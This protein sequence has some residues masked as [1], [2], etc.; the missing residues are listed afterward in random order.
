MTIRFISFLLVILF[1]PGASY[2][3]KKGI[4]TSKRNIGGTVAVRDAGKARL[5]DVRFSTQTGR[6][7]VAVAFDRRITYR[8]GRLSKPDRVFFDIE[9]AL[10]PKGVRNTYEVDDGRLR[11]IRIAQ[12]NTDTVRV[13]LDL[14]RIARYSVHAET[15]RLLVDLVA[16]EAEKR[17]SE[18]PFTIV[19]DPGHGGEDPGA[20]GPNGTVE[21]D[22]VLDVA[23]RLKKRLE[24]RRDVR[25]ILT[26]DRDVFVPLLERTRIANRENA[27]LFLS[28]HVNAIPGRRGRR[29]RGIETYLLNWR[30]SK[31]AE[32]VVARENKFFA[33]NRGLGDDSVL[34]LILQDLSRDYKRDESLKLAHRVQ[35]S[36]V[37]DLRKNYSGVRDLGVKQGRFYV[38]LGAKM[39]AVLA[40]ISFLT[41]PTEAKRLARAPYREA[42]AEGLSR[43]VV[44]YLRPQRLA[45]Y[46]P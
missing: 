34:E 40:E 45:R 36:L 42:V 26:R 32:R 11:S 23:R 6:T 16:S 14:D 44:S 35:G 38:L 25:V 43:G 10:L 21:K 27:D 39:P 28:L 5:R 12:F 41:N 24:A 9:K 31:E 33:E 1:F 15:G 4:N 17:K 46:V 18:V 22:I 20:L 8:Q 30:N 37:D 7:R 13:V 2:A 3:E 29:V 19:I